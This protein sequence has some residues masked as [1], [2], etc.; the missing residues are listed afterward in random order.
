MPVFAL[1]FDNELIFEN[2][3]KEVYGSHGNINT[4]F[5]HSITNYK[6]LWINKHIVINKNPGTHSLD[7][8]IKW[9]N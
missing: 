9:Y 6:L 2:L 4:A 8:I 3:W 7:D 5:E 1:I